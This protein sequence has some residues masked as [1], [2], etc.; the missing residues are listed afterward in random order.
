M[1]VKKIKIVP[2]RTY[3]NNK[4]KKSP[5]STFV[6]ILLIIF[7]G[8]PIL[9]V[10]IALIVGM[11]SVSSSNNVPINSNNN[12]NKIYKYSANMTIDRVP[13]TL[14]NLYPVR[15]TITN[16]GSKTIY[17][18]F[19]Y[20]VKDSSDNTVC[21]GNSSTDDFSAIY[22]GYKET[23]EITFFGC[24]FDEDGNYEIII[25]LIDS[26]YNKIVESSKSFSV[27]YWKEFG[28]NNNNNENTFESKNYSAKLTIEK[29]PITLA[30]LYPVRV[31]IDNIGDSFSPKFDYS[32]KKGSDIICDG[33]GYSSDVYELDSNSEKTL[34]VTFMGCVFDEDGN[35]TLTIDL[36]DPDYNVLSTNKKSFEVNYWSQWK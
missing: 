16:T 32:V 27:D 7:V 35:Y 19:D 15:V 21:N 12:S 30:N 14:A 17:P 34:E 25:T 31:K 10:I 3:N 24:I 28:I 9:F 13:I 4:N 22:P 36:L 33:S 26:S 1:S 23:G 18:K 29:I 6:W 20:V 2:E 8:L 5:F 11:S